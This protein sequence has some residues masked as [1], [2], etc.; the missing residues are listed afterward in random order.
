[1]MEFRPTFTAAVFFIL[2]L[3]YLAAEFAFNAM[4]L[5]V[6]GAIAAPTAE[7]ERVKDFGRMVSASGFTLL[8]L[9]LFSRAGYRLVSWR[10]WMAA[11]AVFAFCMSPAIL[12]MLSDVRFG[13]SAEGFLCFMPLLGLAAL[14]LSGGRYRVY[15]VTGVILMAWPAMFAGQKIVIDQYAVAKTTWQERAEARNVLML[16]ASLEDCVIDLGDNWLCGKDAA[17]ADMRSARAMITA[18]WIHAPGRVI[19]DLGDKQD[20]IVEDMAYKG[21]WFSPAALYKSYLGRATDEYRKYMSDME[22]KYYAPYKKASDAYLG[23]RDEAAIEKQADEAVAGV[24]KRIDDG[25]KE[26]QE[27]M[28]RY[29][30]HLA[31][32][33]KEAMQAIPSAR[34]A[35]AACGDGRCPDLDLGK[36]IGRAQK[37]AQNEFMKASGGYPVGLASRAEFAAHPKTQDEIRAAVE[38]SLREKTMDEA[39]ALPEGWVYDAGAFKELLKNLMREK[40]EAAWNEKFKGK[41]E[42]GLSRDEFFKKMGKG[43]IP[44]MADVIMTEEEFMKSKVVPKNREI[45][46]EALREM[47]A[48]APF[49]ANGEMLEEKGKNYVRAA[50]IPAVALV[51][52]LIIVLLTLARGIAAGLA[53]LEERGKF[54]PDM[55]HR[56]LMRVSVMAAVVLFMMV[57]PYMFPNPYTSAAA[58]K[59]YLGFARER[60]VATATVLDWAIH[61]QPFIYHPGGVIRS[62]GEGK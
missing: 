1:M 41:V 31:A 24:E 6:A 2:S 61:I 58:Y 48:E 3:A 5:D 36:G 43:G 51:L 29:R 38:K 9:G 25:W 10:E 35:D 34:L 13:V 55:P 33:K 54:F 12:L 56:H 17:P 62:I 57:G 21:V 42:P 47:R 8:M 30:S 19:A 49:Y 14:V 22:R 20:K 45:V 4:M 23:R 40:A 15:V 46:Q 59:K 37:K 7:V 53:F 50:Y 26:Y 16:R 52:S 44:D 18:L 28:K 11:S 60:N 32:M 27:G 39:Y